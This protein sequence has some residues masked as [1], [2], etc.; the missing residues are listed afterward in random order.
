MR[1][2]W[3]GRWNG[4]KKAYTKAHQQRKEKRAQA[5]VKI[6]QELADQDSSKRIRHDLE[7][8]DE[9]IQRCFNDLCKMDVISPV[10]ALKAIEMKHK[11]FNGG[12]G[13]HTIYGLEEIRLRETARN[14]AIIAVIKG[15]IPENQW[16]EILQRTEQVT[17]KFYESIGIGEA[18]AQQVARESM[19]DH[20]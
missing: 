9:V 17:R 12:T 2:A 1:R 11:L 4:I 13:G 8:L 20:A 15:Y 3:R 10:M 14:E 18:Y 5:K 16:P 6:N 19:K 7:L